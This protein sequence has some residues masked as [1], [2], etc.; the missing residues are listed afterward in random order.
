MEYG[1]PY[2][3]YCY[4]ILQYNVRCDCPA[5]LTWARLRSVA[6]VGQDHEGSSSREP[7]SDQGV[8]RRVG[9]GSNSYS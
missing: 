4:K 5:D 9:D 7:R 6:S 1:V 2:L 3:Q 8:A